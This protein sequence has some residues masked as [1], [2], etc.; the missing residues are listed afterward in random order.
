MRKFP[1]CVGLLAAHIASEEIS[2]VAGNTRKISHCLVHILK[3]RKYPWWVGLLAA[4]ISSEETS[5][6]SGA[7]FDLKIYIASEEIS[8]VAGNTGNFLSARP[9]CCIYIK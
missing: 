2:T 4:Y 6:V 7:V 3:V 1:R 8:A 9:A 5:L